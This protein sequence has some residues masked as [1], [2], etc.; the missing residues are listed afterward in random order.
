MNDSKL[1]TEKVSNENNSI[2]MGDMISGL[3][4]LAGLSQS[5]LASSVQITKLALHKI[6]KNISKPKDETLEKIAAYFG[7]TV[8]Q[9][10]TLVDR[11]NTNDSE[12][13]FLTDKLF[14]QLIIKNK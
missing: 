4:R 2:E 7:I 1:T 11:I 8:K 5:E 12:K 9:L 6:E 13:K 3:R 10:R 14:S